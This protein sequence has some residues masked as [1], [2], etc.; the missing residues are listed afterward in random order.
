MYTQLQL[1]VINVLLRLLCVFSSALL[2]TYQVK[3]C[4]DFGLLVLGLTQLIEIVDY[5]L[6]C[7]DISSESS[8]IFIALA[9]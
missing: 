5:L 3:N 2:V 7:I 1:T 8:D 6:I 9:H 4:A